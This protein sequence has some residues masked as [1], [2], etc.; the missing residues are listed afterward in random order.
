[1][2]AEGRK[3][4]FTSG[5]LEGRGKFEFTY[6]VVSAR[7][8]LTAGAGLWPAFWTLGTG[9]WP[10]TGEM[11]IMENV[12]DPSWTNIALHGPGY[13]GNTPFS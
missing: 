8:K 12:G 3:F 9:P 5:R 4:D 6:G 1:M 13:S 10:A 2:T 11:D 7:V